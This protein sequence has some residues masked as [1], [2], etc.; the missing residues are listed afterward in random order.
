MAFDLCCR[1]Y[2]KPGRSAG[3]TVVRYEKFC[4]VKYKAVL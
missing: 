4:K 3:K 1:Q 2:I